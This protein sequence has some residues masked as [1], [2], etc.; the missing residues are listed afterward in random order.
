MTVILAAAALL[1]SCGGQAVGDRGPGVD[2]AGVARAVPLVAGTRIA[3][4][5]R[6]CDPGHHPYCGR[7]LVLTALRRTTAATALM[8][9]ETAALR[10]AGWSFGEGEGTQELSALS[11]DGH[12]SLTYATA[13]QDLHALGQG[14]IVRALPVVR[15]LRHD[16]AAGV[17]A[18]SLLLESGIP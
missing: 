12:L 9:A 8:S 6:R 10:R 4:D 18:L 7:E 11:P 17:P 2:A 14:D 13:A 3:L 5:V 16:Q 15:A 1:T